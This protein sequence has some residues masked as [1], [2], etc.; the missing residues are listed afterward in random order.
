MSVTNDELRDF[1]HFADEKL[2]NGEAGTLLELAWEW[3][4]GRRS[5]SSMSGTSPIAVDPET[6]QELGKFFPD[7]AD[8]EQLKQA[9]ARRGG[10]TTAEMLGNAML[11]AARTQRQ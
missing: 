3:E 10:V 11:A 6:I 1:A 5:D 8:E 2:Q 9:L 4:S 7:P